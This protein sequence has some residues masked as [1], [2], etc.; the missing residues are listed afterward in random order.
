MLKPIYIDGS[1]NSKESKPIHVDVEV[2][3]VTQK[4]ITIDSELSP[5]STN[6]VQN[7]V[8]YEAF[9]TKQDVLI[10]D[11]T[12]TEDSINPVTS[13][14]V[15]DA[16]QTKQDT[17]TFDST[18]SEGSLNPVTSNGVYESLQTKQDVLT[19]DQTPTDNS[20]NPVTSNGV[21]ESL[22]TKQDVLSFDSTPTE[23]SN[24]PVTSDGIYKALQNIEPP[25]IDTPDWNQNDPTANDYIKN[26]PFYEYNT[27]DPE[28]IYQGTASS[29]TT[30]YV[31]PDDLFPDHDLDHWFYN[32][33]QV[34]G[35]TEAYYLYTF[36]VNT[37]FL[38]T[39]DI[40][41][42]V[43]I[44]DVSSSQIETIDSTIGPSMVLANTSAYPRVTYNYIASEDC[45]VIV[46]AEDLYYRTPGSEYHTYQYAVFCKCSEYDFG[47]N[48]TFT[49]NNNIKIPHVIPIESKYLPNAAPAYTLKNI[50][51]D[52]SNLANLY[53][54]IYNGSNSD[55]NRYAFSTIADFIDNVID[56]KIENSDIITN[57]QSMVAEMQDTIDDM[58]ITIGNMQDTIDS[59][60]DTIDS[61]QENIDAMQA[62]IDD[63]EERVTA[64]EQE[65]SS[66]MYV[67]EEGYLV[68]NGAYVDAEF[69][70]ILDAAYYVDEENLLNCKGATPPA[71]DM[72]VDDDGHLV[73]D[74]VF[75]D[76]DDNLA[77]N[78]NYHVDDDFLLTI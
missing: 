71:S 62:H 19:F 73:V 58:Q 22:Q 12:P 53:L 69:W 2:N 60:H 47:T 31:N 64:L 42:G 23:G 26:R 43:T 28:R 32:D 20:N 59:M 46:V 63:L 8:V 25:Q 9:Q 21:Y 4:P 74:D 77:F 49:L 78:T 38:F 33:I 11:S 65:Q 24:N 55:Y 15:Y 16:L 14:G 5:T 56:Y 36:T 52:L 34:L 13:G 3:K 1:S 48:I 50:S 75:V 30:V 70:L 6:P 66:S 29:R 68:T 76:E 41:Y 17:L 37:R 54:L 67:D 44:Q 45:S 61:M 39:D 35:Y 18:P 7:K 57:L 40:F 51:T 10:F 72:T 27:Y